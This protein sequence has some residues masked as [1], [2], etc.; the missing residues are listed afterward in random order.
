[1]AQ[2]NKNQTEKL[3]KILAQI[4]SDNNKLEADMLKFQQEYTD[5]HKKI[6]KILDRKKLDNLKNK[7]IK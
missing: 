1:M 2:E 5:I 7:H 3:K 4:T 6:Y